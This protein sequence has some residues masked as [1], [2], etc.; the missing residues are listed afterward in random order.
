M[1]DEDSEGFIKENGEAWRRYKKSGK[2][3]R[4]SCLT[5]GSP[6]SIDKNGVCMVCGG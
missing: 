3:E 2:E 4:I 1:N 5:C 6:L